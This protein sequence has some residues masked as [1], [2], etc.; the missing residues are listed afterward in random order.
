MDRAGVLE[1]L[2]RYVEAW[3]TY[4]AR[5]IGELFTAHAEYRYH[6]YDQGDEVIRGREAIIAAWVDGVPDG[7]ASGRD[8]PGTYEARYEP[9]AVEGDRAVAV[10]WSRYWTD[11]ARREEADAF[12][13]VFLLRFDDRGQCAE[14]T[15]FFVRRPTRPG[16]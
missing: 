7:V 8:E 9:Y 14:F 6:P 15:E 1:W 11:A 5:Q 2:E 12:D 13:N 10:G 4:D 3:R 16:P